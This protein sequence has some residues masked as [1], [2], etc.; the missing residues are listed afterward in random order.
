MKKRITSTVILS[1]LLAISLV[2]FIIILPVDYRNLTTTDDPE[3]DKDVGEAIGEA[4]GLGFA[5]VFIIIIVL[6]VMAVLVVVDSICL[7]FTILNRKSPLKSV[8][9]TNYVLD[10]V[11]ATI[12]IG[13]IIKFIIW[14]V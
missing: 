12:I 3:Q 9:I 4:I 7:I 13:C 1:I 10:G 2:A 8:R 5:A 11:A 6:G 14:I